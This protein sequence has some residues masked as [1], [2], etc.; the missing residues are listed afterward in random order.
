MFYSSKL[1]HKCRSFICVARSEKSISLR[2]YQ[3]K[4]FT[5]LV[6]IERFNNVYV[7][8]DTTL[9]S[10]HYAIASLNPSRKFRFSRWSITLSEYTFTLQTNYYT[11]FT[12]NSCNA[13]TNNKEIF[14]PIASWIY[15]ITNS[16]TW[17]LQSNTLNYNNSDSLKYI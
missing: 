6:Q 17:Q 15:S 3:G 12:I 16:K 14:F 5:Y 8:W 4:N 2:L 10:C 1:R 9:H 13:N 7:T 11:H